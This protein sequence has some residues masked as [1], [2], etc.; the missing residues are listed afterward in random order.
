MTAISL[1]ETLDQ[2]S[3]EGKTIDLWLRDDDAVEPTPAL[4]KLVRLTERYSVPLTLAIIPEHTGQLLVD[5]LNDYHHIDITVHGWS[6][7]NYAGPDEK[8]RELG[9]HRPKDAVLSELQH[10]F[11]K[12]SNLYPTQFVS[13]LVP[14]WNRI[15]DAII[16]GLPDIGYKTLSVFGREKPATLPLL[17][18]H[19]DI[20]DWHGTGGGRDHD[21]L[22]AEITERFR[23]QAQNATATGILT[24]HLVHDDTAWAFLEKLFDL[25][26]NHPACRWRASKDMFAATSP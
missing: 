17:N 21:I 1:R 22:F 24:H 5:Y 19:I 4:E 2:L 11:E 26:A 25:T 16:A 20:M 7:R 23:S 10:G 15:D 14:P 18:T 13:M 6:H 8:K 12:L 9:L 3:A